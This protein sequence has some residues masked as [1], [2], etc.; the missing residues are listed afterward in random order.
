MMFAT[1]LALIAQEFAPDER[2]TA[3]GIW[4]ATTGFAVAVGPLVGGAL[5]D[6]LGWEWI[7]LVNVPIGLLTA[8]ITLA[9]VPESRAATRRS[10]ID[11]AGLVTFSAGALLP[12]ARADP[13]QR[14]G[15]GQR[16]DRGPAG[17]RGRAAGGLRHDRAAP[18]P[19][20]ARPAPVPQAPPSPARRSWPSRSTRRCSRCSSTSCSTCRTCS[21]TRRS[22]PACASCR[23]RSCPSWRRRSPGKLAERL[24]VR[25]FLGGGLVLVGIGLLLMSGIDPRRR[26]DHAAGRV[27][28]RRRGH[29]LHQP[30]ARHR[31]D[32]R[33]R[34]A[35]AAAPPPASTARSARW[36]P[37]SASPGSARSPGEGHRQARRGPGDRRAAPRGGPHGRGGVVGRGPG[38]RP[39][40]S[41]PGARPW[42]PRRRAFIDG[43]NEILVVAAVVAFAGAALALVLVRRR[44]FV[45]AP[46][47]APD[48]AAPPEHGC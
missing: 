1:S 2:G 27:R 4:G 13:R 43:L 19:A 31:R 34:A 21:A 12:R 35:R 44:D 48:A 47:D 22:R 37:P 46:A 28:R 41:R 15:L 23:S 11:W 6:G 18:R 26:L 45:T 42:S 36:A 14:R 10:R 17:R 20:D 29:R 5:T 40:R 8:A 33:G 38:R 9:R 7:F 25:V 24:P 16:P 32:R 39:G 3:F 30:A